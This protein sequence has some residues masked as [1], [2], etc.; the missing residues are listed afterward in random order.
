MKQI[1]QVKHRELFHRS[2]LY[3]LRRGRISTIVSG[4]CEDD[5]GEDCGTNQD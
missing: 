5:C 1:N 2:F 4:Y 3:R